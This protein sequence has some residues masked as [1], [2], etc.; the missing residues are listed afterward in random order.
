MN[1]NLT[2][3]VLIALGIRHQIMYP[4]YYVRKLE[5]KLTPE[6]E[7]AVMARREKVARQFV[8]SGLEGKYLDRKSTIIPI[9]T[10]LI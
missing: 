6:Q 7:E 5:L 3:D 2:G 8:T 9:S 1:A 10:S 4:L